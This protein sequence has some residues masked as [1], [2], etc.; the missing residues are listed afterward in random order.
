MW[1]YQA[2]PHEVRVELGPS[3]LSRPGR[4]ELL[5]KRLFTKAVVPRL[6]LANLR[7]P[8]F[9]NSTAAEIEVWGVACGSANPRRR[10]HR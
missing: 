7:Y 3:V 2:L 1:A 4:P 8:G 9:E 6:S 5:V 10:A